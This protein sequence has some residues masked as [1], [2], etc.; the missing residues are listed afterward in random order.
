MKR[1][2]GSTAF[3]AG[4]VLLAGL[5]LAPAQ[6]RGETPI[7]NTT[8]IGNVFRMGD[9]GRP[10]ATSVKIRVNRLSSADEATRI[11]DILRERG[12]RSLEGALATTDVGYLQIDNRFPERIAAAMVSRADDG[13][14]RLVLVTERP[15]SRRE[16]FSLSRARDYRFRVLQLDLDANGKGGGEMLAAARFQ[17]EKDGTLGTRNLGFLPWRVLNL[18]AYS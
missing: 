3:T 10:G 11:E 4:L 13:S 1:I 16:I 7:V 2:S 9:L 8:F 12:E 14:R 5:A 17:I 15:L 18:H 6:A